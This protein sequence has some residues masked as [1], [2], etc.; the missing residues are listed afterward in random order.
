MHGNRRAF[1]SV[2]S[3]GCALVLTTAA[4]AAESQSGTWKLNLAQSK[5]DPPRLAPKSIVTVIRADDEGVMFVVDTVSS[6]G[7]A[8]HYEYSARYDG[9]D[10]PTTG[11]S[12]RDSNA[13]EKID[14]YTFD[15]T[16]KK[17]GKVTTRTRTI[18]SRDGRLRTLTVTGITA[19]GQ[20]VNHIQVFDRQ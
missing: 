6:Q 14:D 8:T 15:S 1:L 18:Y 20:E 12:A 9:K 11:D 13:I 3:L 2:V 19:D 7:K 17:N 16:A 10:Y 5:Y 4:I